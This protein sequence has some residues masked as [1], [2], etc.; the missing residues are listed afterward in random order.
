MVEYPSVGSMDGSQLLVVKKNLWAPKLEK[1]LK[2][3]SDKE[4]QTSVHCTFNILT[5]FLIYMQLEKVI[6]FPSFLMDLQFV[7]SVFQP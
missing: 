2:T 4:A 7:Y 1:G 5:C 6:C 3:L